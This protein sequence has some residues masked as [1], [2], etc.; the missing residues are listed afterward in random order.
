L[1][2]WE[3]E[4]RAKLV[5]HLLEQ[6]SKCQSCGTAAWEW[7]EDRY[8]YEPSVHQCWGCYLKEFAR[9]DIQ[10]VAGGR[11]ILVPKHVAAKQRDVT[12]PRPLSAAEQEQS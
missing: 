9:D 10:G 8:A 12:R 3:A 2:E 7:E 11:V 1:L 6:G 5:A 4:D